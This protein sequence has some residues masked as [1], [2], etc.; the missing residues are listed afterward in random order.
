MRLWDSQNRA[1]TNLLSVQGTPDW[2]TGWR[3]QQPKGYGIQSALSTHRQ[4]WQGPWRLKGKRVVSGI[5]HL[6]AWLDLCKPLFKFDLILAKCISA[7]DVTIN[8]W[9]VG[10]ANCLALDMIPK[11]LQP[12]SNL[13]VL[14]CFWH[15]LVSILFRVTLSKQGDIIL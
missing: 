12:T 4:L 15:A 2:I 7:M 14:I 3:G 8:P 5:P 9:S 11:C 10:A 1:G 13:F 6:S